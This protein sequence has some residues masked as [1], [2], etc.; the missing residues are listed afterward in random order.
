MNYC[1]LLFGA[2]S[3]Q[4]EGVMEGCL[5]WGVA[6]SIPPW[7]PG[8]DSGVGSWGRW[9]DKADHVPVRKPWFGLC[10]KLFIYLL[11][12]RSFRSVDQL[13]L[14][15]PRSRRKLC[16]APWSRSALP[17][18]IT[19]I[20]FLFTLHTNTIKTHQRTCFNYSGNFLSRTSKNL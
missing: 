4:G 7:C 6:I 17:S 19:D 18:H 9:D 14:Q 20:L 8:T 10:L 13:L 3:P 12:F 5:P 1:Q 2:C 15:V 16:A 11:Y